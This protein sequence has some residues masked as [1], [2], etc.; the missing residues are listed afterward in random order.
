M[1]VTING[2][3]G[4]DAGA[5]LEADAITLAG[6][7]VATQAY[8]DAATF[9]LLA[10][11]SF[12]VWQR[13]T[14]FT[15]ATT[16]VNNDDTYLADRWVNLS[17]GNDIVD[18]SQ[19]TTTIPST[20]LSAIKWDVET[21]N[22][23]FGIL[24]I[25]EQKDAIAIIGGTASLAFEA[26]IGGSNATVDTFRA[27]VISWAGTADAVT[28]DVVS[29]WNV[30]ATD[31]TLVA[32]WTYENTPSNLTLTTSYQE[33]RIENVSIDTASAKNVAVFIWCDN[34]DATVGD[35][36][37]MSNV[38]VVPGAV[39]TPIKRLPH[40]QEL[41]RC[42]RYFQRVGFATVKRWYGGRTENTTAAAF[43]FA[44][45]TTFRTAPTV[46]KIGAGTVNIN[47][48]S[49]SET[50]SSFGTNY[51]T[52][53]HVSIQINTGATLTSLR[54]IFVGVSAADT[55]LHFDAEM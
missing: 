43:A 49:V 5:S 25:L 40:S 6:S 13:G 54:L 32:N 16:I 36:A 30:E 53:N 24:Q 45:T 9:N 55:G 10:N 18:V 41:A 29:A 42:E 3:T 20:A 11:G 50:Y 26:R 39:A 52:A 4:I 47:D 27:A 8:A 14:S 22:K 31:P 17:D 23:K 7:N 44:P 28:S 1:T 37:Y 38:R 2:T 35:L 33:F 12:D 21:A 51:S 48:G 34:G 19:E 15:S 46:A